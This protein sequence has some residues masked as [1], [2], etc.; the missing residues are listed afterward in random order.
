MGR[1]DLDETVERGP[2]DDGE[3]ERSSD[4]KRR[5]LARRHPDIEIARL[6]V[7]NGIIEKKDA[8]DA[9][10][11]QKARAAGGKSRTPFV[12]LLVQQRKLSAR[13]M[14]EVQAEIRRHTYICER[15][16]TRSVI[17]PSHSTIRRVRGLICAVFAGAAFFSGLACFFWAA[18]RRT[19]EEIT[20]IRQP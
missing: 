9:L 12:Q 4:K 16:D 19:L 2:T 17:V 5:S 10:K 3:R 6:L 11:Q 18:H 15:C 14:P 1:R 7:K 20:R 8:L 13:R